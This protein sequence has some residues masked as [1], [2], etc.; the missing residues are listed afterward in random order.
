MF[1]FIERLMGRKEAIEPVEP[2]TPINVSNMDS[3][4]EYLGS[5]TAGKYFFDNVL[6]KDITNNT[7]TYDM[8]SP[9]IQYSRFQTKYP[10]MLVSLYGL[11]CFLRCI[12]YRGASL[13]KAQ[14]YILR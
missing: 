4:R 12:L 10:C 9:K 1:K 5:L 8:F 7:T 11:Y 14:G 13:T 2:F 3:L 6:Q